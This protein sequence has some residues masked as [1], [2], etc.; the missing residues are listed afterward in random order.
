METHDR[1]ERRIIQLLLGRSTQTRKHRR[2]R[3]GFVA[4]KHSDQYEQWD[5]DRALWGANEG[6]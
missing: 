5:S 6:L 4:E 2:N 1:V 3:Q